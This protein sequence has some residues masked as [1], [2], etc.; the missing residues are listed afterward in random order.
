MTANVQIKFKA[1][2]YI[3]KQDEDKLYPQRFRKP[4]G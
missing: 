1:A 4:G 2:A 3:L